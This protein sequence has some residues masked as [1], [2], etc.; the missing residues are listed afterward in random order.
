MRNQIID[1]VEY[2]VGLN[3]E[4]YEVMIPGT[5]CPVSAGVLEQLYWTKGHSGEEISDYLVTKFSV[6]VSGGTIR[7]W[8]KKSG[9][10]RR[11]TSYIASKMRIA[12]TGKRLAYC[13]SEECREKA[14]S[15]GKKTG[16]LRALDPLFL[17]AMKNGVKVSAERRV[18]AGRVT[19]QCATCKSFKS[20]HKFRV[21][22]GQYKYCSVRC[23][24]KARRLFVKSLLCPFCSSFL[25]SSCGVDN[26]WRVFKCSGCERRTIRPVI[27]LGLR[28]DL[29]AAGALDDGRILASAFQK[30]PAS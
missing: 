17:K 28:Q 6:S 27:E 3:G 29:E 10:D 4:R 16:R 13:K 19:I 22:K 18:L 11:S 20:V 15:L 12:N 23:A 25:I 24:N 14:R 7:D 8:M 2:A 21:E 9:I 30:E 5:K 1:G 26:G